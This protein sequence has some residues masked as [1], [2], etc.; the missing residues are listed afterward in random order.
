MAKKSG[1]KNIKVSVIM[2]AY[3]ASEFIHEAIESILS[4]TFNDFEFIVIDDGSIDGTTDIIEE[5]AKKDER[6]VPVI[7]AENMGAKGLIRNL[8]EALSLAQG[9]YIARMD[10]DDVSMPDRLEKQVKFLNENPKVALVGGGALNIDEQGN[11]LS[12][13]TPDTNSKRMMRRLVDYNQIYNPTVMFR[14]GLEVKYR[15]IFPCEDYDLFLQ[16]LKQGLFL[17]NIPSPLLKYRVLSKSHSH[18]DVFKTMIHTLIVQDVFKG[19]VKEKNMSS[20]STYK[21]YLPDLCSKE[22]LQ[23]AV[24]LSY[25]TYE[26]ARAVEMADLYSS[27]FGRSSTVAY[28]KTLAGLKLLVN[29]RLR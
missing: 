18:R 8:N 15:D 17:S 27:R 4:Q 23:R 16:M 14:N 2:S 11:V 19:I 5:F 29:D 26:Y 9:E 21:K 13:F 10:A 6:I 24:V 25:K 20:E 22:I 12:S 3:N 7:K 28:Y 1:K